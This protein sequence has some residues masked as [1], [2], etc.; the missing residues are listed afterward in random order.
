MTQGVTGLAVGLISS[1]HWEVQ[2]AGLTIQFVS[3][4]K[5]PMFLMAGPDTM[6]YDLGPLNSGVLTETPCSDILTSEGI[7]IQMRTTEKHT[8][9]H[10]HTHTHMADCLL[11]FQNEQ[12]CLHMTMEG[13]MQTI[14]S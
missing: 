5:Y 3:D 10:T 8:Q 11:S 7:A 4:T 9:T 6:G 13:T 14:S 2:K 12:V 1:P